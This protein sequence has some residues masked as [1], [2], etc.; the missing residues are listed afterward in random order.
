MILLM[1]RKDY[2]KPVRQKVSNMK[3]LNHKTLALRAYSTLLAIVEIQYHCGEICEEDYL[4]SKDSLQSIYNTYDYDL[5]STMLF[6]VA[7]GIETLA[8]DLSKF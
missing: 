6:A 3:Q 7:D 4:S 5:L 1:T 8:H 2:V